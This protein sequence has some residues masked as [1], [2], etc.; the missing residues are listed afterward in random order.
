MPTTGDRAANLSSYL[1]RLV[2]RQLADVEAG[3]GAP[4]PERFDGALVLVD[5]TGFT[6]ITTAAIARGPTGV[7]ELS[8]SFN[9]YL[10]RIIDLT[11]EHGGDIAKFVGDALISVWAAPDADLAAATRRAVTCGL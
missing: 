3:H 8:R 2:L 5:I 9:D 1:S 7:E 6:P 4:R 10:G 11:H